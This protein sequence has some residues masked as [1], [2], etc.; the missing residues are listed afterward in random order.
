MAQPPRSTGILAPCANLS[1]SPCEW[2]KMLP[3]DVDSRWQHTR[4]QSYALRWRSRGSDSAGC[5]GCHLST[6]R[7]PVSV[8]VETRRDT[9]TASHA[10]PSLSG[11]SRRTARGGWGLRSIHSPLHCCYWRRPLRV[12]R[13]LISERR[14]FL[15]LGP[16][17]RRF[18]YEFGGPHA[19]WYMNGRIQP[20]PCGPLEPRRPT[21]VSIGL[22]S[23]WLR[24]EFPG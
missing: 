24:T 10:I 6:E 22:S 23:R 8:R 2:R 3:A 1:S 11:R 13:R 4:Q 16:F 18:K 5:R 19:P 21:P 12:S 17:L 7:R 9:S 14:G 15:L 20:L